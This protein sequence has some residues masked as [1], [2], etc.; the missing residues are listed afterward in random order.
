MVQAVY[1]VQDAELFQIRAASEI[2]WYFIDGYADGI[3]LDNPFADPSIP[4]TKRPIDR[5]ACAKNQ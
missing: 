4:L 1:N 5:K 2:A 3:W